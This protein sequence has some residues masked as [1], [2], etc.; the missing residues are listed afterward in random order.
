MHQPK[1]CIIGAGCSGLA[2]IKAFQ[3]A[4]LTN[5]TCFEQ[6]DQIGG[7]WVYTGH[8]SHSSVCE[9]TFL[10]SSKTMSAYEG[11]PMPEHY[12]EY[13]SH[14]QVLAY[15]QAFA[16]EYELRKYI[17]FNISVEHISKNADDTWTVR[18][19]KGESSFDYL[20]IANG[21][22]SK[23]RHP[24]FKAHFTGEYVHSHAFKNNE[25]FSDKKVL[26][27]GAGNSGC[28][29]ASEISRVATRTD[30]SIR[31]P[32]Y[33]LPKFFMGKPLDIAGKTLNY[34]PKFIQP[35]LQKLVFKLQV[36]DYKDYNLE[37]PKHS[38]TEAHP[39]VNSELLYKIKHGV[40]KPKTGIDRVEGKQVF[41][42]DGT[43]DEYDVLLAATGYH[44][45]FPFFDE[46]FIN[47]EESLEVPLYLRMFHPEH[48]NLAF[49][50]L[51]QPQ[52]AIWP[53]SEKQAQLYAKYIRQEWEWPSDMHHKAR[54]DADEIK[55]EF[56]PRPRHSIEVHYGTFIKKIE[57]EI[58][59]A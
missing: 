5:I 42:S 6:N 31:T 46:D 11:F 30:I 34:F 41:F 32:Q 33:I 27:V 4:G 13:P 29:C 35:L 45:H 49:I 9:T 51:F 2:A 18:T 44:I 56:L 23:P 21:H 20:I 43:S 53:G 17:E 57:K 12:P 24:E 7:N 38:I 40:V 50:G 52:G 26:I 16:D 47:F 25:A 22:H 59:K 39:T 55:N 8:V 58:A 14:R 19:S 54:K 3:D 1:I 15:F 37:S 36:G 28:D 48:Q 10:I